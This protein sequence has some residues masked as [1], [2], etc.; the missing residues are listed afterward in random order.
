MNLQEAL[1]FQRL[2]G[3]PGMLMHMKQVA[4]QHLAS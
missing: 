1:S 2:N 4:T 3:F